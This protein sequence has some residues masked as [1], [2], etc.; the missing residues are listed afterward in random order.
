VLINITGGMDMTLFEVDE[1][2]NRI[3]DEVDPDANIIFGS[4][5]DASM[6][7][8]MRVSVVATGIE[9]EAAQRTRADGLR[10]AS[11]N[12]ATGTGTG[13]SNPFGNNIAAARV[14]S[15][16]AAVA[17]SSQP[18]NT[19]A[20]PPLA[21]TASAAA[22]RPMGQTNSASFGQASAPASSL[23]MTTPTTTAQSGLRVTSNSATPNYSQT[24]ATASFTQAPQTMGN[25]ALQIQPTPAPAAPPAPAPSL[26]VVSNTEQQPSPSAPSFTQMYSEP[27]QEPTSDYN[28]APISVPAAA[29]SPWNSLTTNKTTA[30]ETPAQTPPTRSAEPHQ[31][32]FL[33][34]EEDAP[35]TEPAAPSTTTKKKGPSLFERVTGM[36]TGRNKGNDDVTS[37]DDLFDTSLNNSGAESPRREPQLINQQPVKLSQADEDLLEIPA[38]LRRQAN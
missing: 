29:P 30:A 15:L 4:T 10:M 38:F 18:S 12:A 23:R 25:A 11:T 27:P 21:A 2:A 17:T 16:S 20:T 36:A 6:N 5:F 9:A 37:D 1:A 24:P 19:N 13:S 35:R 31:A 32:N 22:G 14:G 8:K 3:R 33:F 26:T 28:T 34:S 7:G